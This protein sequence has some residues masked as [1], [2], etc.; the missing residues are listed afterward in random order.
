M[1]KY[2]LIFLCLFPLLTLAQKIDDSDDEFIDSKYLEDQ[3]YAGLSYNILPNRPNGVIQRNLS[4]GLQ[5]G[6]IKDIPFNEKRNFGIAL[7]AGYA[8]NS[9]YTNVEASEVVGQI[10][11]SI[12]DEDFDRSKLATHAIE[13]PLE[14]RWRTSNAID[15]KFWRIYAG[16]KVNY[17]FSRSSKLVNEDG[18]NSFTNEDIRQWNYGLMLNFGYNTFN[19]HLYYELNPILNDLVRLGSEEIK[20]QVFRVGLIFYIL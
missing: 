2:F 5:L 18:S 17:N 12:P 11:Y 3:F 4:Y 13:F 1:K 19:I 15:Y 6:F 14:F 8:T 16:G 20:M 9:Y 7:G 10:Q